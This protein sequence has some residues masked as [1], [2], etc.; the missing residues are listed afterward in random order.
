MAG[1]EVVRAAARLAGRIVPEDALAT[2]E[3]AGES[4]SGGAMSSDAFFPFPDSLEV[5]ERED[6]D[7]LLI[8][9]ERASLL[10]LLRL[11]SDNERAS[12]ER[13][14]RLLSDNE[15]ARLEHLLRDIDLG[16]D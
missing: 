16:D 14:L 1:L 9:N 13:L 7:R 5:S 12:L 2:A 3:T 15:R 11:L 10:R 6:L 4:A 8:D